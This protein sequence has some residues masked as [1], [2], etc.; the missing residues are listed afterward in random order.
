VFAP[1]CGRVVTSGLTL[2]N[3]RGR[4]AADVSLANRV[5]SGRKQP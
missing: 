5:R 4:L 2:H 1:Q 3:P